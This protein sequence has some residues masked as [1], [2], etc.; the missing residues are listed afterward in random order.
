[1]CQG[2]KEKKKRRKEGKKKESCGEKSVI[3]LDISEKNRYHYLAILC[4]AFLSGK[5]STKV[6][7]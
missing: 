2:G 6:R 5:R 7:R 3:F 4:G 1:L